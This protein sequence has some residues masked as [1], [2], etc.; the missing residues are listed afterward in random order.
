MTIDPIGILDVGTYFYHLNDHPGPANEYPVVTD[1]A[2]WKF[3]DMLPAHW[4]ESRG[5][6]SQEPVERP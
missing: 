1:F 3:P 6:Q 4:S 2:A 5:P